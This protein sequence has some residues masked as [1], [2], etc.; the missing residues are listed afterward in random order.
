[1]EKNGVEQNFENV[2]MAVE[3]YCNMAPRTMTPNRLS[4]PRPITIALSE[5]L[6]LLHG[7]QYTVNNT[8]KAKL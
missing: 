3:S 7:E 5:R 6:V 8:K 1:M 4:P 2:V